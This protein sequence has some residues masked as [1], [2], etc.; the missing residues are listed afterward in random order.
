MSSSIDINNKK[1]FTYKLNS[2]D[3]STKISNTNKSNISPRDKRTK[4]KLS[5]LIKLFF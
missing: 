2:L 4:L 1:M 3:T 5:S